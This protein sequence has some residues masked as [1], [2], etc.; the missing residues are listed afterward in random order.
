M[1]NSFLRGSMQIVVIFLF[2]IG[3]ASCN[4]TKD[5]EKIDLLVEKSWHLTSIQKD[6]IE[7]SDS[8]DLDDILLFENTSSFDYDF[9]TISCNNQGAVEFTASS[10]KM[11]DNFEI[12]QMKY[13]M[14]E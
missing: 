9:G 2:F 5:Y 14:K 3:G 4:K 8:C 12:L 1:G 6:G 11:K 10:W 7:I 13:K